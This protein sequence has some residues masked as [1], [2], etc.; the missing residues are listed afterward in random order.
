[1]QWVKNLAVVGSILVWCHGLKDLCGVGR[2]CGSDLVRGLGTSMCHGCG[3]KIKKKEKRKERNLTNF[4]IFEFLSKQ[5]D[6]IFNFI[7]L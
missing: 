5:E 4:T 1:M 6:L 7:F 3:H 2:T